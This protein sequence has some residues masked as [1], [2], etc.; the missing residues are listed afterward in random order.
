MGIRLP[1][2]RPLLGFQPIWPSRVQILSRILRFLY[3]SSNSTPF[4]PL[5]FW[6]FLIF[7]LNKHFSTSYKVLD[8]FL[9]WVDRVHFQDV[10]S[11]LDCSRVPASFLRW[12]EAPPRLCV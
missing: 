8:L 5:I 7:P 6:A 10:V 1:V 4:S 12:I 2:F 9:S 3:Q 11:D